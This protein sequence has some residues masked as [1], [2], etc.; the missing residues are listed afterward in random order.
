MLLR[1]PVAAQLTS[2]SPSAWRRRENQRCVSKRAGAEGALDGG[3]AHMFL[4]LIA[5]SHR[6]CACFSPAR[7]SISTHICVHAVMY[8]NAAAR[9]RARSL[10]A[11]LTAFASSANSG[12]NNAPHSLLSASLHALPTTL[13]FMVTARQRLHNLEAQRPR[14]SARLA[15]PHSNN[16]LFY[17]SAGWWHIW[18]PRYDQCAASLMAEQHQ[19][20]WVASYRFALILPL[21]HGIWR[22]RDASLRRAATSRGG[23][24]NF[25]LLRPRAFARAS[26]LLALLNSTSSYLVTMCLPALP[27]YRIAAACCAWRAYRC[28]RREHG[29]AR[30]T[31]ICALRFCV[32]LLPAGSPCLLLEG[33]R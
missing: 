11:L 19:R 4:F 29:I 13:P 5:D 14:L 23:R 15:I 2:F 32:F 9:V 6:I 17:L 20:A 18:A 26:A 27:S 12:S 22:R 31:A 25:P 30:K 24:P 28:G 33:V 3:M 21:A 10:A 8:N 7:A 16:R 1:A